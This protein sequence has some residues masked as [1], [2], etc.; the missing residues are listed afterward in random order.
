VTSLAR[1]LFGN[2]QISMSHSRDNNNRNIFGADNYR[3]STF[4][5]AG[6]SLS[7]LCHILL[8][9]LVFSPPREKPGQ[10]GRERVRRGR[11]E[12]EKSKASSRAFQ[13]DA[14]R[15]EKNFIG[16]R[17]SSYKR[18]KKKE[19]KIIQFSFNCCDDDERKTREMRAAKEKELSARQAWHGIEASIERRQ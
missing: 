11:Q 8:I 18:R 12:G 10:R 5:F 19:R 4:Y 17:D 6:K 9:K 7:P 14:K 16:E 3:E 1:I 2:K 13:L 15:E